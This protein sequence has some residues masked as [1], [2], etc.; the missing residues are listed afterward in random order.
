MI[1]TS[2][3]TSHMSITPLKAVTS[4]SIRFNCLSRIVL[5]SYSMSQSAH[6][7]CQ[8]RGC[9]FTFTF[10]PVRKEAAFMVLSKAGFPSVGS[11]LP[12]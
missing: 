3:I 1:T 12:Q 4:L 8:Q 2:L 5:L 10:F 7:V 11:Y 9:P 6:T